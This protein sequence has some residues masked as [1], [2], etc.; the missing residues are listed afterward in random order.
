MVHTIRITFGSQTQPQIEVQQ[1]DYNS[2]TIQALCYSSSGVLMSFDG[3]TVSVVYDV[4]GNPSEEYPVA[5]SGNMLTF[6]MPGISASTAGSGKLQLRIYG[7]ESLLHSAVIPYTVKASLEPGQGQED[8]VPMLVLLVQQAQEAIAGANEAASTANQA[9]GSANSAAISANEK[10]GIAASAA[11]SAKEAASNAATMASLAQTATANANS[12]ANSASNAAESANQ[13]AASANAAAASAS[14]VADDVQQ[15]AD[16][17]AFNGKNGLDAPQIDDTQITTTNPWSSQQIID[18]LCPPL[19]VSGN[20]VQCYPVAGYPLGVKVAWE[21]R[22]EGEGDPS[23]ENV[24]PI[25]G[26]DEVRATRA[27]KNLIPITANE[28]QTNN[29]VTWTVSD[30]V[31][32]A[33]GTA[34]PTSRYVAA[35]N[36]FLPKGT[37]AVNP[38]ENIFYELVTRNTVVVQTKTSFTLESD[39]IGN[40][41]FYVLNGTTANTDIY[42]QIELGST[43]TAYEPY[44]GTTATL[45]LPETIYGG[46]V[47]AVTGTGSKTWGYIASYNGEAL[48]WEWISD[49]DVYASGTTPTTGAQVAYKLAT[50][51]PFQATGSQPIPALPGTNTVYTDAGN[52]TVTGASDPTATITALQERVSALESAQTNM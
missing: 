6:T 42:P 15:K 29:G 22:Q 34:S 52:I 47:D 3:K 16:S 25:A 37:Y 1:G 39:F 14:Q 28:P 26:L 49:R 35:T 17:G 5:V 20:P 51:E 38:A 19:E 46:T 24:R 48:P 9:A 30:G 31:I 13:A 2:R 8:Q 41:Q 43:S 33:Q 44:T 11:N 4:A 45:T 23:P 32:H 27:G 40:L 7:T 36:I 10:A 18:T 50:P 12:A 21:P